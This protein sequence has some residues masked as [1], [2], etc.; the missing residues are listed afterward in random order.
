MGGTLRPPEF[1]WKSTD[2][3]VVHEVIEQVRSL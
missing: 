1:S 3:K 2:A